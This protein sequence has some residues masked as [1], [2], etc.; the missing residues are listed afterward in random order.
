MMAPRALLLADFGHALL[1]D[2]AF[3]AANPG[4]LAIDLFTLSGCSPG[5]P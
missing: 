3:L 2:Q 4:A 1:W 5:Q